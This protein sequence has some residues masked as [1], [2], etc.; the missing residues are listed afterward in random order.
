MTQP[1]KQRPTS[2]KPAENTEKVEEFAERLKSAING[3]FGVQDGRVEP[4]KLWTVGEVARYRLNWWDWDHSRI[5]KSA[6]VHI[7]VKGE[8]DDAEIEIKEIND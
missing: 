7:T 1:T 3:H 5:I 8:G 2:K 6:F 4:R